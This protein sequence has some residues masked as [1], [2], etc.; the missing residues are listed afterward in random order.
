MFWIDLF[1]ILIGC[2]CVVSLYIMSQSFLRY[3][4]EWNSKTRDY[5]YARVVWTVVGLSSAIEGIIR[6]TPFRYTL[7]FIAAASFATLKGNLQ[8][9]K[10]GAE[11]DG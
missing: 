7:I 6:G 1:R 2:V 10:W 5:W 8:K 3:R 9:G 4:D 11:Q